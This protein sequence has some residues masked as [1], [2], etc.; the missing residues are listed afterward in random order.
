MTSLLPLPIKAAR[1]TASDKARIKLLFVAKH[2]LS[3]GTPDAQDGDHAVYH[4]HV[5]DT[6]REIGFDL[7]VGNRPN[8]LFD[9]P[10]VDFVFSL[11]NRAGFLNSEMLMPL[12][13]ERLSLPY[14]GASP[15]LRGVSDDKHLSKLMA[16]TAGIKTA[17]WA[18][19]RRFQDLKLPQGFPTENLIVKP[20]ASSGS[21]GVRHVQSVSELWEHVETLHAEGHD[22]IIEP[23]L[24]GIDLELP[25]IAGPKEQLL[26]LMR[27]NYDPKAVRYYEE[28]RGL[29]DSNA[30]L[31][32]ETDPEI[33]AQV[34]QMTAPLIAEF[35]PFDYGRFEFRLNTETGEIS[36]IEVNLQCNI[37]QPRVIGT[38]ARIAGL[39]Y[40][41]LLETI[42][43][44]SMLRRGVIKRVE[45]TEARSIAA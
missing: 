33:I 8:I 44:Y 12:L 31:E 22:A 3:D 10:D 4:C 13:C 24:E 29:T 36:F 16:R 17:D 32:Q 11:L 15:I 18:L 39:E 6:L 43:A 25:V 1:L 38:S 19:I 35:S 40:P 5:R 26:P 23:F 42:L 9:K 41:E 7:T 37:W 2:A 21:W 14:L 34:H 27:F 20:N 30:Q 45:T 28:K